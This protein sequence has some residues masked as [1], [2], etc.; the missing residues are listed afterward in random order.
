MLG[1]GFLPAFWRSF[2]PLAVL[3]FL[4]LLGLDGFYFANHRLYSLLEKEDWPALVQFLESRVITRNKYTP[5]LV[6]I[7][8]NSYLVLSAPDSLMELENKLSLARPLLIEKNKLLFGIA[9]ILGR[10]TAG[11]ELFFS[12]RL[13]S[14]E[15]WIRF[16]HGFA[17]LLNQH[18][19]SAA[20]DFIVLAR[21]SRTA[22]IIGLAGYFLSVNLKKVLPPRAA[23]CI[24]AGK[25]AG[26]RVKKALPA[27]KNWNRELSRSLGDIH[28][29]IISKYAGEAARWI[30][31]SA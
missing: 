7:L 5:R 31:Q 16:Y 24:R 11:A 29:A 22:L 17:A 19:E 21:E 13:D 12:K 28:V 26:E 23:E 25:S 27:H 10:D 3:L 14:G 2:W 30:Y 4:M 1:G 18:P 6:R 15:D 20:D 9:H 8:A